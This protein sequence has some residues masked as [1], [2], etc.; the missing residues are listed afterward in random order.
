MV[1]D[2]YTVNAATGQ[3]TD[4]N[5]VDAE[6]IDMTGAATG[7]NADGSTSVL[8]NALNDFATQ[9]ISKIIDTSTVAGKL[10]ADKLGQG[11]YTDS[12]ATVLGQM[13]II[14]R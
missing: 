8:G 11:N 3:I 14:S 6:Q 2:A 13:K 7:V 10:L 1:G 4:R 5:L 9:N 12:K